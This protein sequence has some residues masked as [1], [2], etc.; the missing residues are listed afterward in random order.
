MRLAILSSRAT[1]LMNVAKDIAYVAK[2]RGI[3]PVLLD[4]AANPYD[5]RRMADAA[6]VVMT[7]NPL[8]SRTWFL[9]SR[10]LNKLG[11]PS[12]VYTTTEGRLPLR[13]IRDWMRSDVTYVA[14]SNYTKE[15]LMEAG[16]PVI[17]V[18]YHGI[19]LDEVALALKYRDAFR[20]EIEKK[21]GKGIIFGIVAS[22]HPRK[23]LQKFVQVIRLVREKCKEA[24]F[25]IVTTPTALTIFAGIEGVYVDTNFGKRGKAE[26][27]G[28]ISAFDFYVHPSL[29]EGFGLPVLESNALGVPAIHLAYEPLTEFTDPK[30]N[31]WVP[32]ETVVTNSFGEGIDYE[33]HIYNPSEFASMILEAVEMYKNRKSEYEDRRAR[34]Q[35][36]ARE[37]DIMRLYTR[38]IDL[39]SKVE[40][41]IT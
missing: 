30:A 31:L 39:V 41:S 18:V 14:N 19:N 10:D 29:A 27:L 28:L 4:Y 21:V 26:T 6:I 33:L 23:G 20:K 1:S 37:F 22:N 34:A 25:Y 24:K 9:L 17:D 8:M 32:Y 12:F 11:I 15:K 13:H 16:V 3:T 7:F 2:K 40:L 5:I 36:K 35:R 38:L